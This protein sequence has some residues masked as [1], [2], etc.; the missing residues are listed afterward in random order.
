MTE[1]SKANGHATAP[2][3][4]AGGEFPRALNVLGE[5]I[6]VL[7]DAE[8]TGGMELFRQQG[9]VGQGPPPHAHGW[10]E[11]FYVVAGELEIGAGDVTRRLGP[12]SVA[13]V[14]AGTMHWFRFLADGEMISVTSGAGSSKLFTDLDAATPPGPPNMDA[15]MPV[16]L[17]NGVT[18]GGR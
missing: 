15:I 3:M 14:P 18:L 11:T 9:E 1:A 6:T 5:R 7:A 10:D 2:F 4:V 12:G 8:H 17:A 16:I 13:H